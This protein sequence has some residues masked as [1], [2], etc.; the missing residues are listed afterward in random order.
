MHTTKR[1][2]VEQFTEDAK[3]VHGNKYDYSKVEYINNATPVCIVCQEH[4]DF[5]QTPKQHLRGQGC[6]ECGQNKNRKK[7]N[8]RKKTDSTRRKLL[9]EKTGNGGGRFTNDLFVDFLKEKYG[10]KYLYS[11]I[12]YVNI[13]TPVCV[14]CPEHGDFWK[15]PLKLLH[16][17][18]GCPECMKEN[19]Q[20][21][22][23]LG[24]ETF[25]ERANKI[26]HCKYSYE[27]VV[28]KNNSTKVEIICPKHG[29]FL[30]SPQN[31]LRGRGCPIC[32]SE[33]YVY[34]ERLYDFLKTF[35]NEEEIIRQYRCDWLTNGKSL[36]FYIPKYKVG[37]EHQ[38]SQH[39]FL[40]RF[41]WD[42]EQRLQ[43]QID[44]DKEK[45]KECLEN[46][47]SLFYFTYEMKEKPEN[48]FHDMFFLEEDLK[49]KI[50]SSIH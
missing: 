11:K 29:P 45:Y 12:K 6:P 26:H 24:K 18:T 14:V 4:G 46:G 22:L 10:E 16:R 35:I 34:E 36:D 3:A 41:E 44:N 30:C 21:T 20:N 1:K 40:T 27:N 31:H 9:K 32:K 2:T 23:S 13:K 49:N 47:V 39:Y 5:W 25:I 33:L 48:C 8:G 7:Q 28:Y 37:I 43:K 15:T 50:I 42:N 19:K 17:N 38:G